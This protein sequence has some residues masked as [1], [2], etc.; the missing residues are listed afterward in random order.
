MPMTKF[1]L[2]IHM[3]KRH[4]DAAAY[5]VEAET[6]EEAA[7]LLIKLHRQAQDSRPKQRSLIRA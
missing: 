4:H 6:I 3:T 7:S 2:V 5:R 1:D